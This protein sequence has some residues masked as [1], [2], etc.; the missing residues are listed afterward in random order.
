MKYISP[1]HLQGYTV[2]SIFEMFLQ[3][4]VCRNK[5]LFLVENKLNFL[6]I[7]DIFYG[8]GPRPG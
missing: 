6:D 2:S 1:R 7:F 8:N 3:I 5:K 4:L